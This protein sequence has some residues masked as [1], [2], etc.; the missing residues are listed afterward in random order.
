MAFPHKMLFSC[1]LTQEAPMSGS[2]LDLLQGTLHLMVLQT[3]STISP[4]HSYGIDRRIEQVSGNQVFLNQGTIYASLFRL[5]HLGWIRAEWGTSDNNRIAKFYSIYQA[6]PEAYRRRR[7]LAAAVGSD[8]S[9]S[10]HARARRKHQLM[11][12][13][14]HIRLRIERS[15][16][17]YFSTLC[18]FCTVALGSVFPESRFPIFESLAKEVRT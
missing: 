18:H 2:R 9:C 10:L 5:Q 11:Q 4:L 6:L 3:L 12:P 17:R 7:L 13:G 8:V 14:L 1:A 15:L 16:D